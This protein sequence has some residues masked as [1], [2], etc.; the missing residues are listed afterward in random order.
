MHLNII[1]AINVSFIVVFIRIQIDS[2]QQIK[3]VASPSDGVYEASI[4]YDID[5][6]AYTVKGTSISRVNRYGDQP[7]CITEKHATLRKY[8]FCK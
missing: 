2:A 6:E 8:C 1:C 3:I 4:E 5:S 7:N